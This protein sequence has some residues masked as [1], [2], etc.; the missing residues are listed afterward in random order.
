[1]ILQREIESLQTKYKDFEIREVLELASQKEMTN[2][3]DAYLLLKSSKAPILQSTDV[4]AMKE[5][6]RNEI[7]QE[8]KAE[9]N[10][11]SIITPCGSELPNVQEV[12]YSPS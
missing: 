2:L 8:L 9:K 5:N 10:T 1:M 7:L 12:T 11:K 4:E 6:L 3:E